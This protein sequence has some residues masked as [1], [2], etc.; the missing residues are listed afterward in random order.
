MIAY[1]LGAVIAFALMF[2]VS[3]QAQAVLHGR[4][5]PPGEAVPAKGTF[6]VRFPISYKEVEYK[7]VEANTEDSTERAIGRAHAH[8][9]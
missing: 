1:R 9:H 5:S 3:A 7:G 4:E 8:R 6:S 2:V